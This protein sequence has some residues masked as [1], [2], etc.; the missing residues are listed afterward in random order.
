MTCTNAYEIQPKAIFIGPRFE[1]LSA[2]DACAVDNI[3]CHSEEEWFK[4]AKEHYPRLVLAHS[5][6]SATRFGDHLPSLSRCSA[7]PMR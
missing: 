4:L 5:S 2:L 6:K 7:T 3:T 1:K